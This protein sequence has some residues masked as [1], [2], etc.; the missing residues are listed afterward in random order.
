MSAS[1]LPIAVR[2][3]DA[4][5]PPKLAEVLAIENEAFP[6]CERL[7]GPLLQHHAKLRTSG[8]LVAEIGSAVAGFLL[9]SK[10]ADTAVIAKIAVASA[11]QRQGVGGALLQH[12]IFELQYSSRRPTS[13]LMLHVDPERLGARALYESKGFVQTELLRNYYEDQRDAIVMKLRRDPA[14]PQRGG[15]AATAIRRKQQQLQQLG[16]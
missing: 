3:L 13:E 7:G 11:F 9:Y 14:A 8:L 6:P 16:V 2:Q 1:P 4:L 12:G 15:V 10:Q 5:Q